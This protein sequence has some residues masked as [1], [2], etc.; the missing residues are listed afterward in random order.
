MIVHGH[1]RQTLIGHIIVL[2]ARNLSPAAQ[3]S[4][5]VAVCLHVVDKR[6]QWLESLITMYVAV[7]GISNNT[8]IITIPSLGSS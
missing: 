7:V 1:C 8:V 6:S 3:N 5:N 4:N 2:V